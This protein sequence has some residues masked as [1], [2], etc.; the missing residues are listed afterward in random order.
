MDN[1]TSKPAIT[2]CEEEYKAMARRLFLF[3]AGSPWQTVHKGNMHI[4][5][6]GPRSTHEVRSEIGNKQNRRDRDAEV[7]RLKSNRLSPTYRGE[8]FNL[9]MDLLKAHI[10]AGDTV[11]IKRLLVKPFGES[12]FLYL[13]DYA[14]VSNLGL[15][16]NLVR[17][18]VEERQFINN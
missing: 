12:S 3:V 11:R 18:K 4:V 2:M 15:K 14:R 1:Q 13:F 17:L 9:D 7:V 5:G 16:A 10:Q 6:M 8:Y